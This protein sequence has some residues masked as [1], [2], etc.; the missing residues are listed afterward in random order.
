[1]PASLKKQFTTQAKP[2]LFA[3]LSP[4]IT[5]FLQ[6]H[7]GVQLIRLDVGDVPGPLVPAAI[8][9]LRT[10]CDQ[11]GDPAT[12]FGYAPDTGYSF[13]KGAIQ[14]YYTRYGVYLQDSEIFVNDG[15]QS[16]LARWAGVFD[17]CP[18]LVTDPAYP[19]YEDACLFNGHPIF[20]TR[21]TPQNNFLPMPGDADF[22]G[23]LIYLC[24]PGNP[25]GATYTFVQLQEWVQFAMDTHSVILYDAAY[26]IFAGQQHPHSIFEIDG[27]AHCAIELAT[28]S[29]SAYF[30]GLRCGWCVVPG[31][32]RLGGV[33]LQQVWRRYTASAYNG[34]AYP[35]Q[36]AA[37]AALSAPGLAQCAAQAKNTLQN[38]QKIAK[39]LQQQG[40]KVY[41][42]GTSPYLWVQ[43]PKGM[44]SKA[45][46]D[47]LLHQNAI[48]CTPGSGFGRAGEGYVR[49]SCFG[50]KDKIDKA[51]ARILSSNMLG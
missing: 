44:S 33:S 31:E 50:T 47:Y 8:N 25:I 9:A 13:L 30:T 34:T 42:F 16:D 26:E 40:L 15:V 7:P 21:A 43:C 27:A 45:Y 39:A 3:T 38:A 17:N 1:M 37:A 2:Y 24:S 49:I 6:Q 51:I 5:S 19:A 36:R 28:L 35:I 20:Y 48:V 11:L 41:C 12:F 29:K 32:L 14:R 4:I 23:G 18:A 10:A 46:F 22:P